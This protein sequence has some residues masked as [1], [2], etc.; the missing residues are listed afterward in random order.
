MIQVEM[1]T[2][3][4]RVKKTECRYPASL[5]FV[6]SLPPNSLAECSSWR[7]SLSQNYST[8]DILKLIYP[9]SVLPPIIYKDF[10]FVSSE[11]PDARSAI[12]SLFLSAPKPNNYEL[13][14]DDI[15]TFCAVGQLLCY[16]PFGPAIQFAFTA[17]ISRIREARTGAKVRRSRYGARG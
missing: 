11:L 12:K 16:A 15:A 6:L 1:R 10:G 4:K 8:C 14:D 17:E 2:T 9:F 5:V 3:A 7:N 13:N